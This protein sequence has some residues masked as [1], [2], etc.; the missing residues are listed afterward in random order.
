MDESQLEGQDNS[1][2]SANTKDKRFAHA[3]IRDDAPLILGSNE[4]SSLSERLTQRKA[5]SPLFLK[6]QHLISNRE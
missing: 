2:L 1:G 6:T 3:V 4:L 5:Q